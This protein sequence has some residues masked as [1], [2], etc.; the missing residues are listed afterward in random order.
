MGSGSGEAFVRRRRTHQAAGRAD[1][2]AGA[3]AVTPRL[4]RRPAAPGSRGRAHLRLLRR[5]PCGRVPPA[6]PRSDASEWPTNTAGAFAAMSTRAVA[7]YRQACDAG[8][9]LGCGNLER[10]KQ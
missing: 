2:A 1:R 8:E 4:A 9:A 10:V 6:D 3:G 5:A 7:L